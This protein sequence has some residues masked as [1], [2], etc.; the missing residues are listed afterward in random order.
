MRASG[1]GG[2]HDR[3]GR[4][5]DDGRRQF[6][7]CLGARAGEAV[8]RGLQRAGK[9]HAAQLGTKQR[10]Q[11]PHFGAAQI[12][13]VID[14]GERQSFAIRGGERRLLGE[15]SRRLGQRIGRGQ[16]AM[17]HEFIDVG[18]VELRH[19][20]GEID[21]APMLTLEFGRSDQQRAAIFI[22]RCEQ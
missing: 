16:A 20:L 9:R 22:F 18:A 13:R 19:D 15:Q 5:L 8:D 10:L 4:Q 17:A 21:F 1:N 7:R 2:R 14:N 11:Q 3:T 12:V 6:E